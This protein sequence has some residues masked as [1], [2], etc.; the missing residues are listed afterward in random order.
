MLILIVREIIITNV[1][2]SE[3]FTVYVIFFLVSGYLSNTPTSPVKRNGAVC[4]HVKIVTL[5]LA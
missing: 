2:D 4:L 3:T 1:P 5:D